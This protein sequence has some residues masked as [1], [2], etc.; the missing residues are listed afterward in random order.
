MKDN[1]SYEDLLDHTE[2]IEIDFDPAVTSYEELLDVYWQGH[3]PARKAWSR[4]YAAIVLTHGDE[5][6]KLAHASRAQVAAH[7]GTDVQTEIRAAGKFWRA[8]DY[9]QKYRLRHRRKLHDALIAH[10][11]SDR[12][13]VDSTAAA[14][15]NGLLG[16]DGSRAGV[17][18]LDLPPN[19]FALLP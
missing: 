4:Q 12:A 7:I 5:Q 10:F 18:A 16:G 11:G 3:N 8:E 13:F 19:V 1:P 15:I 14:R 9:H 6:A 17:E 2:A